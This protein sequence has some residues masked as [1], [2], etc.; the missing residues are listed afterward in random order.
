MYTCQE[1][2]QSFEMSINLLRFAICGHHLSLPNF[3]HINPSVYRGPPDLYLQVHQRD[4]LHTPA[5][6]QTYSYTAQVLC[7]MV[8]AGA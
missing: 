1:V 8:A 7:S 5:W 4:I 2:D 6:E 3:E